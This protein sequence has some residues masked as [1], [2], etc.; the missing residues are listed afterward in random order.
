MELRC[1]SV[2]DVITPL[3][4][5][6]LQVFN[7]IILRFHAVLKFALILYNFSLNKNIEIH[8]FIDQEIG[9][10]PMF[11]SFLDLEQNIFHLKK[12]DKDRIN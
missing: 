3:P 9:N 1:N 12:F 8:L 7:N 6:C 10:F 5:I 4:E 11:L 2:I